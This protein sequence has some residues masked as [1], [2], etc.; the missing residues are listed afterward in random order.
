M[1]NALRFAQT[2]KSLP[3]CLEHLTLFRVM[4]VFFALVVASSSTAAFGDGPNGTGFDGPAE[5]PRIYIQSTLIDTPAPG[6]E[7]RVNI[8]GDLQKALQNASCGDTVQLQAGA[9]FGGLFTLP[10][11]GCDDQHWIIIRTSAPDSALPPEG[12]RVTPCYAGLTSLPG[13][14][15]FHCA[16]TANVMARIVLVR[17]GVSGPLLLAPGAN[18]YRLMGLE[19]TR[20]LGNG[21]AVGLIQAQASADHII[22]DRVWVHGT[23]Q[24]ETRRG[25][26]LSGITTAAIVDSYFSDF[27]CTSVSGTCTDSQ[28]IAGG[29]S[30][31]AGGPYK[32]VNNFLE[33]AGECVLFGGDAST[34]V[35]TD[36]EIRRNHLFRPMNWELGQPRFVGGSDGNP[37][38]VK[39]HF[40]LKNAQRVLF[41]GNILE[42]LWGGFSQTGFSVSLTPKGFTNPTNNMN[43][44]P[45]CQVT[46]VTIRYNTISHVAGGI[47]I[48]TVLTG[49]GVRALAGGRYSIHD[50]VMDDVTT[51]YNGPGTLFKIMNDWPRN[52]LKDV[53]INH[54]TGFPDTHVLT[55]LD[56]AW[57]PRI[58][59]LVFT[60]NIVGAGQYPVW[61]ADGG[62]ANC[63]SS[64]VPITSIA[65]CFSP[66]TFISNVIVASPYPSS[67]WPT[68]NHFPEDFQAVDFLNY[69]NHDYALLPSSPYWGQA[70]D[71]TNPGAD[72][73]ALETAISGVY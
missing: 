9:S 40:E 35:P 64:N 28:A 44:C 15:D 73:E 43:L 23:A 21:P 60:N 2:V 24:D 17:P 56:L 29:S 69:V 39:N 48:A 11:K 47:S 54:V 36:L 62:P 8:G 42:N 1:T 59:N 55:L 16:S 32:I 12:V 13:R 5:L 25:I 27:H 18:H 22:L 65:K 14:P 31:L 6:H 33:A 45:I 70:T 53:T 57:K 30:T 72:M 7:I 52:G 67:K 49:S 46:D 19:I 41:E 61:S 51:A 4:F 71:G 26:L 10:D 66:Y 3:N 37:F 50:V 38:I 34:T 63:A 20:L 68:G 58:S